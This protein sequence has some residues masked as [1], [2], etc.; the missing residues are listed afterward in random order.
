MHSV[1]PYP[2]TALAAWQLALIAFAA[3]GG[4]AVWL[5][6]VFYSAREPRSRDRAALSN[7]P[8]EPATAATEGAVL[9]GIA[10]EAERAAP[11]A[12]RGSR[13]GQHVAA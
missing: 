9:E 10:P 5:G 1:S 8:A 4:V 11:E 2:H 13:P 6:A 12:E 3:L 7:S